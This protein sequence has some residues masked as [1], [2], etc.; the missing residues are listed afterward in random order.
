M[1][2]R[3]SSRCSTRLAFA[4]QFRSGIPCKN[5]NYLFREQYIS[6]RKGYPDA[7]YYVAGVVAALLCYV[8]SL[9]G[10]FVHD[11]IFAVKN[12]PDVRPDAP[13]SGVFRDDF[14]GRPMASNASHKSYRPLCVLSFRFN[15]VFGGLDP[16][17]YH[18]TNVVLHAAATLM[19]TYVCGLVVFK[20]VR[21]AGLA[22]LLFAVHPI[23]TEADDLRNSHCLPT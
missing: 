2:Q 12:N 3:C 6:V 17:G 5:N 13:L 18:V 1:A 10:E 21:L 8:N 15:Y 7:V 9:P 23:H 16:V 22:G 19:F 14:W 20:Q 4:K 11:D